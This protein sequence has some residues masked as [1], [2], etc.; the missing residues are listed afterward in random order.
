MTSGII[1]IL[2]ENTGVQN[3]VGQNEAGNKYKVYPTVCPQLEK[4]PYILV[5]MVSN[6]A[7]TSLDKT[8]ESLL[9]Y[10]QYQVLCYATNFRKTETMHAACRAALDN[11][12]ATT[13]AGAEFDRIWLVNERDAFDN[14]A[15]LYT[16]VATYKAEVKR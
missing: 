1:E 16:K 6:D 8:E 9:D 13:D 3:E 10:P 12:E 2:I 14:S 4:Q 11:I 5:S 15:Q 7:Q